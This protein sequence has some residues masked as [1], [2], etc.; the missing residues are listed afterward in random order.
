[1]GIH[2]F[3][4]GN[5]VLM[6][7]IEKERMFVV[8]VSKRVGVCNRLISFFFR[9]ELETVLKVKEEGM[10]DGMMEYN[11]LC[12]EYFCNSCRQLR[13]SFVPKPDICGNCGSKNIIVGDL[14]ELNKEELKS[15]SKPQIK[16]RSK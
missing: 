11:V 16:R 3:G 4:A 13:G 6:S 15:N 8:E 2:L 7:S 5:F 10:M 1:M 14:N 9:K 12:S